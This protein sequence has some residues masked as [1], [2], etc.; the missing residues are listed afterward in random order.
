MMDYH[1][2]EL[3]AAG[4]NTK[5]LNTKYYIIFTRSTLNE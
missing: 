2:F 1:F 5:N 3:Y 4:L